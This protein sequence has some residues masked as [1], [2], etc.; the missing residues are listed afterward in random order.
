M[1]NYK[2]EHD[3]VFDELVER[4]YFEQAT[5]EDELKEMLG[6][7]SVKFYIGFDATADS[8][9]IGHFIQIM[10]MMRMQRH[11]HVPVALL[12]GGTTMIGDPSGRS[13]MRMVMTKETID[14]NAD[15]FAKQL[16]TF[17][18]F[19]DDK[20]II[21]NNANWLLDLNFLDFMR[22][23]GVHFSVN[24]ML[25]LD[26]YKNR[27]A[28]GLTFF[29]FSYMLMQ[30]YDYLVLYRKYGV[31]LQMGGSDQWSN[32]LGGYDLVRKLEH[33]KVYAMTFKLL[34][35]ADGVKMGKSQKGA[36]WLDK[37]KTSP[38]E[39]FQYMRNIDD[40]DVEKFLLMLTFL[41]TDECKRLGALEGAQIN[42]AKETLAFEITKLIH[43]EEEAEKAKEASRALFVSGAESENIPFTEI[44]R[45]EFKDGKGIL[46]LLK[47]LN[48]I[49]SNSEGRRLIEQNGISI[50]GEKVKS[51]DTVITGDNFKEDKILIRKGKKIYHQVK[52]I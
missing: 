2:L 45:S 32:I 23:I 44:S 5:Y 34:T 8:L 17:L 11:G 21:E 36:V 20:A 33:D 43:G 22:E 4:G 6:K 16:A 46:D 3:N 35:T 47:E 28:D 52:L 24:Q 49:K 38:Y 14:H 10:V 42:E 39:L 41:P 40:R 18:D 48:L 25:T 30:S 13:D 26:S 29:E 50:D 7:E 15:C 51:F 37:E 27:M 31:K 1:I 19:E 12:G 9:T